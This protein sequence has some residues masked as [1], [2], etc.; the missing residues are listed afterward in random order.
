MIVGGDDGDTGSAVS[1]Q[2]WMLGLQS[3]PGLGGGLGC[4]GDGGLKGDRPVWQD[5][6]VGLDEDV[7]AGG[8]IEG[9][10]KGLG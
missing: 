6:E 5:G 10:K 9:I 2:P 1:S 4:N 3:G 7:E 8:V